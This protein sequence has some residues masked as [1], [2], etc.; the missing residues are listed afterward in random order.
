MTPSFEVRECT[1]APVGCRRGERVLV[2]RAGAALDH[3]LPRQTSRDYQ[4]VPE[5]PMSS[6]QSRAF[7]KVRSFPFGRGA[8]AKELATS[9][10]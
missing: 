5:P 3:A 2:G 9:R 10:R 7:S 8:E 6:S 4:P 1:A